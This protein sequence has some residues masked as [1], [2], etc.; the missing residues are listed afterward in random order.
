MCMPVLVC[1]VLLGCFFLWELCHS[2]TDRLCLHALLQIDFKCLLK[3]LFELYEVLSLLHS[4]K[5]RIVYT[6][7]VLISPKS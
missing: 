4:T 7:D 6:S 3:I 5:P 1:V 2:Y